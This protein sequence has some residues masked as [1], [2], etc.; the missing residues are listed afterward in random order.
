MNA[1]ALT[2][3][4]NLYGWFEF[5]KYAK[6]SDIKPIIGVEL[7]IA[8]KGRTNRDRDNEAHTIVLLAQDYTGFQNLLS[9]VTEAHTSGSHAGIARADYELLE[10]YRSGLIALSGNYE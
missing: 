6:K 5:Y 9:I 8:P 3:E 7:R 1:L 2:D 4:G 10:K